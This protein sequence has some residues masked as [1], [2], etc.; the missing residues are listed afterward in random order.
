LIGNIH[1]VSKNSMRNI[2]Q[3]T[4]TEPT[5]ES[6]VFALVEHK[7]RQIMLSPSNGAQGHW[8]SQFNYRAFTVCFKTVSN[9]HSKHSI[10]FMCVLSDFILKFLSNS[11]QLTLFYS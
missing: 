3:W 11:G 4:E 2:K 10:L 8:I 6:F 1:R 5:S 9:Q 7:T